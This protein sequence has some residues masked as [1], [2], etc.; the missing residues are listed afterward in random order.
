MG[1]EEIRV[2]AVLSANESPKELFRSEDRGFHCRF[3]LPLP[4]Y[5]VCYAVGAWH[6]YK[7]DSL[8]SVK[9]LLD[10]ETEP[11]QLGFLSQQNRA[12]C[13]QE[14]W[15]DDLFA[16]SL[17]M[18]VQ[19]RMAKLQ[20]RVE[21]GQ[22]SMSSMA[23]SGL[24]FELESERDTMA[25]QAEPSNTK[26]DRKFGE[27]QS[28]TFITPKAEKMKEESKS[29]RGSNKKKRKPSTPSPESTPTSESKKSKSTSKQR[30]L[31][32]EWKQQNSQSQS[33]TN[34]EP[35]APSERWGHSLCMIGD[36]KALLIGGQGNKQ[37]LSK[38]SVWLLETD[39]KS[40][41]TPSILKQDNNKPQF[42]MG[43]TATYD[44]LVKCVYVFG[45]SKNLRWYND[46]H[47][48]DVESW[49][50]SLVKT[51]GKAPTR[52]Y[53]STTL[54]RNELFVFGGVFP[55]PDPEPDGCS[56]E[57][58][59]YNPA[60]ENW[61]EPIVMGEKPCARSGHSATLIGESLVIFGGW[62]APVSYQDLFV[63]DLCIMDFVKPNVIGKPPS[64]RS[65]HAAV[66]L[67]NNRI[68]IHGGYNGDQ[69]LGDSFIFHLDTNTWCGLRNPLPVTARAGH[70]MICTDSKDKENTRLEPRDH[71]L[72]RW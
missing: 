19:G 35:K 54:Y 39:K 15:K 16:K 64:P 23:D 14:D 12:F 25:S 13:W 36:D 62:D 38:D 31:Q 51:N 45:G 71:C 69:A 66:G 56:N 49:T 61:Y 21:E 68:L 70:T 6:K 47:V 55:N 7:P 10:D 42:R 41:Q 48:L 53:H 67:S 27:K 72:W 32:E 24:D 4:D 65:W 22:Q 52:A 34:K 40:W 1:D 18:Q 11:V 43:H 44:P 26:V 33:K 59:V 17:Q 2:F 57:L 28:D 50:W 37:Q 30:K 63:L 5:I 29:A 58:H 20:V 60:N 46:V 3:A 8:L 9:V